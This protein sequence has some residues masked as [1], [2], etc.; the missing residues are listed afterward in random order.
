MPPSLPHSFPFNQNQM[1]PYQQSHD[2]AQYPLNFNEVNFTA[3]ARLPGLGAPGP[4]GSLPPPPFPFMGN[5][6]P[7]QFPPPPF[8]PMQMPPLRYPPIPAAS[9]PIDTPPGCPLTSDFPSQNSSGSV[10]NTHQQP[11]IPST[12]NQDLDRE[13]GELTDGEEALQQ[14]AES[15]H[16]LSTPTI[17]RGPQQ[18]TDLRMLNGREDRAGNI[19][20]TKSNGYVPKDTRCASSDVEEGEASSPSCRSSSRDSGSPYNPPISVN[21]EP[22]ISADTIVEEPPPKRH[23]QGSSTKSTFLPSTTDSQAMPNG[24]KSPAQLRVQAQ[25]ALLSLAPHNIRY[26]E[27]VGEGINPV[28]LKQLYEEVGIKVPTPQP[29]TASTQVSAMP[30]ATPDHSVTEPT[31]PTASSRAQESGRKHAVDAIRVDN[32]TQMSGLPEHAPTTTPSSQQ[33]TPKPME[34][35]EVIARMLAAK[36]AKSSGAPASPQ[37]NATKEAPTSSSSAATDI[38]KPGDAIN[39]AGTT[40]QEKEMR[41]REKNKAQTE[42]AR[43]RIEQLK[44]QG[45]MRLQ[46]KPTQD[47]LSL[48]NTQSNTKP[49]YDSASNPKSPSIQH[50]LPDRPPDPETG[51]LARIPG[52]FMTEVEEKSPNESYVTPSQELV[53]DSTPQPRVNQRKRPR[54]SD[55]DEPVPMPRKAFNNGVDHGVSADRLIIDIS[56]DDLYADDEDD[57]MEIETS[58]EN[59]G[60]SIMEGPA[61]TYL[62]TESLPPRP[63]TSS[64]LGFSLSATPQNPRNHDQDDLRRKDLEIQ[65]MHRRIAEL[66]QRKKAKLAASRTQ[67]PRTVDSSESSPPETSPQSDAEV[68]ESIIHLAESSSGRDSSQDNIVNALPE[69][70]ASTPGFYITPNDL[71]CSLDS[72]DTAQLENMKTK[73]L[74]KHEIESGVPALEAEIQKSETRLAEFNIEQEKLLLEIARGKE[75]RQ[76]LLEELSNLNTEL[77]GV[78]LEEV[79]SALDRLKGKEQESANKAQPPKPNVP[80]RK[81]SEVSV[82]SEPENLLLEHAGTKEATLET[83]ADPGHGFTASQPIVSEASRESTPTSSSDSTGS[84]MDESS[85]SDSDSDSDSEDDSVDD[86]VSSDQRDSQA[87][88]PVPNIR[89]SEVADEVQDASQVEVSMS[90]EAHDHSLPKRSQSANGEIRSDRSSSSDK[91]DVEMTEDQ[92][93][94]KSSVSEA[95]EPPEPEGNASPA[96][97]VYTPPFSPASPGP[98][99]PIVSTSP[100]TKPQITGELPMGNAQGPGV[101]Q[102]GE[103]NQVGLLDNARQ[104]GD[105]DH[106]FSPY[107]SPLKSF[108]AYR[109]HPNYTNDVTGG[110]RSLTYSHN[111]DPMVYLCPFE[112][113]GGVCNDR[114]CEFQHFRDMNLS[115]DKILVQM[116]SLREGKTPEE[117]D[118]YIAGL[119]NIIN[120]MRRDKVK[121][122]NT[123]ANEIAAY[124]RRFLQDPSRVLPL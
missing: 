49:V 40:S 109:Y 110:Y 97:L 13:E 111:I 104:P 12:L 105:S 95:Y 60:S 75:G 2:G 114:S 92:A 123:V 1:P 29:D 36:A 50:P 46:Q 122:F 53:V 76:Q 113:A 34:R 42:L 118:S 59:A 68:R 35:K 77:N 64:S 10:T 48:E 81:E 82:S 66:E 103:D 119:K 115:D 93:S 96:D 7:S 87:Q 56:D 99:E 89:M 3:N 83:P 30:S 108:K 39:S 9:V 90:N 86:S 117:K 62:S 94:A 80:D 91:Q 25:G 6:A 31:I 28:I 98:I 102:L 55:F 33:G 78:S 121:D 88:T 41:V 11:V 72:M 37:R 73:V 15:R 32:M 21:A 51:A 57:A 38:E 24:G 85:D 67:S 47:D 18:R 52:L 17:G 112:G 8:P 71:P 124:R 101:S 19:H 69:T 63:V 45:L 54:A 5:F 22:F 23:S 43:Q 61:R 116:G 65:A 4:V 16:N 120:D 106:K 58:E 20:Q 74:R 107:I 79:E 26:T 84:S 27:L 44:K 70:T 14:E 100:A